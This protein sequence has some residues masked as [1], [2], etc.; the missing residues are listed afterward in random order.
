MTVRSEF[1]ASCFGFTI[2]FPVAGSNT[3]DSELPP[4]FS[5]C[6]WMRWGLDDIFVI[7]LVDERLEEVSQFLALYRNACEVKFK[8]ISRYSR[9]LRALFLLHPLL[10]VSTISSCVTENDVIHTFSW[11]AIETRT[12]HLWTLC[13]MFSIL[14]CKGFSLP[15]SSRI[16]ASVPKLSL[17][18]YLSFGFE[19]F[20]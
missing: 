9:R 8:I 7:S 2:N 19:H 15:N 13:Y 6:C 18:S 16:L 12:D 20:L 10:S 11:K 14:S 3:S 4:L 1:C 17:I 5:R